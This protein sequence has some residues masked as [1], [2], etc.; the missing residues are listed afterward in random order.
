[1]KKRKGLSQKEIARRQKQRESTY[2][3]HGLD[4]YGKIAHQIHKIS[5]SPDT[6]GIWINESNHMDTS[7]MWSNTFR[8]IFGRKI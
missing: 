7:G 2:K 3:D 5:W 6:S 8:E 1:M 4:E